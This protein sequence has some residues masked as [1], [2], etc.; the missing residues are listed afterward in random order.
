MRESKNNNKAQ[1]NKQKNSGNMKNKTP[2]RPEP[3]KNYSN[4][5]EAP[6]RKAATKKA[7][8]LKKKNRLKNIFLALFVFLVIITSSLIGIGIGVFAK[9]VENA[10]NL[11]LI[12]IRPNAYTSIVYDM[13]NT[14]IDRFHGNEN[15]EYVKIEE[16]P[17]S[18]QDSIVA[19]EDERF[20]QHFGIDI[21]GI[22]RATYQTIK[23]K[24]TG[25]KRL[26]GASTITQQLIKNNVTKVTR[27]SAKTKIQEQYLAINYEK[28]LK[29]ELGSKEKAKKYIL[30][31]YLNTIGLGHG[32]N[33][34]QSAA[35]GY[36]NKDA[37]DLTLAESASIS[38]ITNNPSLYSPRSNPEN[39]KKRQMRILNKMLDQ[40][41]ITKEEY[42]EAINED[43]Y[44]KIPK[45]T[46]RK[47]VEGTVIHSYFVDSIFEQISKDLQSKYKI[48]V[49]Q[50]NNLIYNGGL[51][52]Y[53]SLDQNAQ[54]IVDK[55][56][57]N[58]ELFPNVPYKIDVTYIVSTQNLK[59]KKQEHTE[60][61]QFVKTKEEGEKFINEKRAELEANLAEDEIIIAERDN[62]SVQP[63][64]SMV[65]IDY[66][67]G[68]VRA[69]SGGRDEKIV[70]R[71]FNRAVDAVRQPGSVFKVLAAFAPGIDMGVLTPATVIDDVPFTKGNYSPSNWYSGY[72]GLSTVREAIK[73]S[74]N[75]I[76]VKALDKV[77]VQAAYN[78]LLNLG[79]TTLENDTHLATALG[80]LTKGVT[81]LEVTAAY[82][83]IANG[84]KYL[85][86]K[87]Y[88][89]VLDNNGEILLDTEDRE[90]V[91][92]L[93]ETSSFLLTDM[94]K[95]V[96]TS[97]TGTKAKFKSTKMPVAG[98]TGTTQDTKD[99]TFVGY[100]PY[101]VAGIWTGYDRYDKLVP[102]MRKILKNESYH[103]NIWRTIM[104]ELHKDLKVVEFEKPSGIET[105]KIC[106]DSGRPVTDL[107]VSDPRGS[108]ARNEYFAKGTLSRR[109]C[110]VHSSISVCSVSNKLPGPFC[111]K[112][113]IIQ[114]V[115]IIRPIEYTGSASVADKAYE[116]HPP[117]DFCDVHVEHNIITVPF[118]EFPNNLP[119]NEFSEQSTQP[120][121]NAE[122]L[123]NE[124]PSVPETTQQITEPQTEQTS[125]PTTEQTTSSEPIIE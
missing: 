124:V 49:Q 18:L 83:T 95:D 98:K 118:N 77:G 82:G 59:T 53:S 34:V 21:K 48:S 114:R 57:L 54:N 85:E 26:Q 38:A 45:Q 92:V 72:R 19:V 22:I 29:E 58:N 93:K 25:S 63:Q 23:S 41:F 89:K 11:D 8:T 1:A 106:I 70:N 84:G 39:N 74:M 3:K 68:L 109:P 47:Q 73:D 2:K 97:G 107:C 46:S 123:G 115:G 94:M 96:I 75:I 6:K 37:K 44:S 102:N 14:E 122:I 32:Y 50:A 33:G 16:I 108:R 111:P 31:L 28:R 76:A 125:A 117:K 86:P 103:L 80:G 15:R 91:Q 81:Q 36:F 69:I 119:F 52:I 65:I 61:K 100:T 112:D 60:Y 10:P 51:Q 12:S 79:F 27:N 24:L 87:F 105:E 71:G 30:E 9:I 101:Y 90:P 113:K 67:K 7:S 35:L 13:N 121:T 56:Y 40:K 88:T 64:S 5:D 104:E 4:T 116:L 55:T 110:S 66:K 42:D 20:Y 62:F 99:L 78:Y 17:K 43:I 120:I